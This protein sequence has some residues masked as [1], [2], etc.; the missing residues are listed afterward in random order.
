MALRTTPHR[1]LAVAALILAACGEPADDH[2]HHHDHGATSPCAED[3]RGGTLAV[4]DRF[5][6][7]GLTVEV[8]ALDPAPPEVGLNDWEL[9]VPD[10]V[11]G[12]TAEVVPDMPDH[13]HGAPVGSVG[14]D[15]TTLTVDDLDLTM[16]GYWEVEV[17]LTCGADAELMQ[18]VMGFCVDA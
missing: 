8:A 10:T 15:G 7:D 18:A 2:D 3:D 14:L 17:T 9:I 1:V 12:C 13:G 4:G 16:G 5:E 11:E 6:G